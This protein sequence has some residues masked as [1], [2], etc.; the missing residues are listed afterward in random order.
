MKKKTKKTIFINWDKLIE[1]LADIK[2]FEEKRKID[3]VWSKLSDKQ[4]DKLNEAF[5][6]K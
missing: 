1:D 3:E 4:K 5:G 2:E 6:K